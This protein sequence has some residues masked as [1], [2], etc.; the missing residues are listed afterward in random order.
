MKGYKS[1]K[2]MKSEGGGASKTSQS[3]SSVTKT[4]EMRSDVTKSPSQHNPF[5]KGMS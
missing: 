4:N 2:P 3:G 5:P 1:E